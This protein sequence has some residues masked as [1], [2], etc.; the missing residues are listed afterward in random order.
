MCLLLC[1]AIDCCL[2]RTEYLG[3]DSFAFRASID[4]DGRHF[5]EQLAKQYNHLLFPSSGSSGAGGAGAAG[6]GSEQQRDSE[7]LKEDIMACYAEV[8]ACCLCLD[9]HRWRLG[10]SVAWTPCDS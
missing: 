8:S 4:F 2:Q 9:L 3:P 6:K 10:C 5:S 1:A 7:L